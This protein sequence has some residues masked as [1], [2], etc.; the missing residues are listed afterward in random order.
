MSHAPKSDKHAKT[1]NA[2][3]AVGTVGPVDSPDPCP[4]SRCCGFDE[5]IVIIKVGLVKSELAFHD[6]VPV[7]RHVVR[8]SFWRRV[9]CSADRWQLRGTGYPM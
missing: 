1:P 9:Y 4:R 3:E 7:E 6:V 5:H 8:E 2:I